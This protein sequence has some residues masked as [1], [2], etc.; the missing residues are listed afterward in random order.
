MKAITITRVVSLALP[1]SHARATPQD[2]AFQ[3]IAH[4]YI[5]AFLAAEPEYATEL[6]DHRFDDQ[7][8]DYAPEARNRLL[9]R[10]RK[11]REELN[12][13]EN[14]SQL[15]GANQIDVRILRDNIDNQIFE[16]EELKEPDWNPLVYNQSL[17]NSLY[18]LV[19]R[20]FDTPEKRIT[21]L[22]KRM[23]ASPTVIA[24]AQKNL[25]HPP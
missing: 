24:Q 3:K 7:L 18:L 2:D 1:L 10:T 23:E 22:R 9:A 11:F 6:G 8:R 4:D 15:T 12:K 5:E 19:V 25:Q 17:D 16:L 13:F 21:N 14:I 20:D